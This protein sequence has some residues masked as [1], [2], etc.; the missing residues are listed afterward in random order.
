MQ[1]QGRGFGRRRQLCGQFRLPRLQ[2]GHLR[3]HRRV[4]HSVFDRREDTGNL[5]LDLCQLLPRCVMIAAALTGRRI[6]GTAIFLD[7]GRDQLGMH[8]PVAQAPQDPFL[9]RIPPDRCPVGADR[10]AP[11][12]GAAAA[13]ACL[14]DHRVSRPAAIAAHQSR[15]QVI[16][17]PSAFRPR[18]RIAHPG[19]VHLRADAGLPRLDPVPE[20]RVDYPQFGHLGRHPHLRRVQTRLALARVGVLHEAL[21]VPDP[22]PDIEFVVQDPRAATPVA[23][24]C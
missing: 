8:Q 20:R 7:E 9:Q 1:A 2:H 6:E 10:R 15:Q 18:A 5:L 21:P 19:R 22:H 16:R 11:V 24:D 13:E 14:V 17:P 4:I 23:L 12:A 3:L